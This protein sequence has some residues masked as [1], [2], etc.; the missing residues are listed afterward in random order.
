[1]SSIT[2]KIKAAV[3]G[4]AR[5]VNPTELEA[6]LDTAREALEAAHQ[7][8]GAAA[9]AAEEHEPGADKRLEQAQADRDA[10][11]AAV[12]RLE[13]ALAA[14]MTRQAGAEAAAQRKA[15]RELVARRTAALQRLQ[16]AAAEAAGA[17]DAYVAARVNMQRVVDESVG[18]FTEGTRA[19]INDSNLYVVPALFQ[20][21]HAA[22]LPYAGIKILLSAGAPMWRDRL[23]GLDHAEAK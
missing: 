21:M 17:E 6:Q 5:P 8:A 3:A 14:A 13:G 15:R 1:M 12:E 2:Q 11:A 7:A 18:M 22:G 16:D 23:P 9:L 4:A 19:A 10:A 20:K